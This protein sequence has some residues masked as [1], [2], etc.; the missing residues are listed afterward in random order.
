M[1]ARYLTTAHGVALQRV[2]VK[3]AGSRHENKEYARVACSDSLPHAGAS[4][5][6]LLELAEGGGN[7]D[8]CIGVV[9]GTCLA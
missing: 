9:A 2:P 4:F 8:V 7:G 3:I 1:G 5:I 6:I